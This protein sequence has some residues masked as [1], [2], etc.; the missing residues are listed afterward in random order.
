[1]NAS[2]VETIVMGVI[3]IVFLVVMGSVLIGRWPWGRE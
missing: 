2:N 3:A 1:M